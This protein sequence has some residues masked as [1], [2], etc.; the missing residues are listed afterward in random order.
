MNPQSVAALI[1]VCLA[2]MT[3]VAALSY[4]Y[5][6][7]QQ[8]SSDDGERTEALEIRLTAVE[9]SLEDRLVS[10]ESGMHDLRNLLL[11]FMLGLDEVPQDI[12]DPTELL[13]LISRTRAARRAG[14]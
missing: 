5:G 9:K 12:S 3:A 1:S 13:R 6:Q 14:V 8:K 11:A 4:R 2:L 7:R 10:V